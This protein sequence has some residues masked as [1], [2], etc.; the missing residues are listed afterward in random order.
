MTKEAWI[1]V[2][3]GLII[4]TLFVLRSSM[5]PLVQSE[6]APLSEVDPTPIV[7]N[8]MELKIEDTKIGAGEI[9]VV[10]STISVHYVGTFADGNKFDSSRDRNVPFEITLGQ[11]S[12]I[13]GW[14]QG[15]LG[16]KV[17]GIRKLVIPPHLGYGPNGYP[18]IIPGDATLNFDIELVSIK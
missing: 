9:A 11:N 12:V 5:L 7:T 3:A 1:A 18:P 16:M 2:F 17:G 10:G 4:V 6:D 14:E 13:Q 8:P 15:I